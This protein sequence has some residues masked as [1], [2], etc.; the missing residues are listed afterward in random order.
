MEPLDPHLSNL[1]GLQLNA[2]YYNDIQREWSLCKANANT[3][4]EVSISDG[5]LIWNLESAVTF[6]KLTKLLI[7]I[8]GTF[9]VDFRRGKKQYADWEQ[10]KKSIESIQ[11]WMTFHSFPALER[12]EILWSNEVF[13]ET[14]R[15]GSIDGYDEYGPIYDTDYDGDYENISMDAVIYHFATHVTPLDFTWLNTLSVKEL[16]LPYSLYEALGTDGN[17]VIITSTDDFTQQEEN[18]LFEKLR[19]Y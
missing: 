14:L 11:K 12:V 19:E 4:E 15:T 16:H 18:E 9:T 10:V 7:F 13:V 8:Q 2:K 3:L 6:R 5:A 1:K 17:S